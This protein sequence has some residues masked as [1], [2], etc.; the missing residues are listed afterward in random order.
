MKAE[1]KNGSKVEPK[2]G[3]KVR[4][5]QSVRHIA[6]LYS[7]IKGGV[8]LDKPVGDFFSPQRKELIV[9]DQA[10]PLTLAYQQTNP[11]CFYQSYLNSRHLPRFSIYPFS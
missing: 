7:D 9:C 6:M 4:C 1:W 11:D 2:V 5:G 3:M 8:R 10:Q